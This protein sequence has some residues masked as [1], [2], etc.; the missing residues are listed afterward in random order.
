M[1]KETAFT[2]NVA[3]AKAKYKLTRLD[4]SFLGMKTLAKSR[5]RLDI[6]K[7]PAFTGNVVTLTRL[8]FLNALEDKA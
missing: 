5:F 7:F 3:E 2:G 6:S 1:G 4:D 8:Q